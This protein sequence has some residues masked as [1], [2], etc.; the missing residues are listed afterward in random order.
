MLWID[1][2]PEVAKPPFFI[3]PLEP[4]HVRADFFCR[5]QSLTEYI[6]GPKAFN[7][8][9]NHSATVYV[10]IDEKRVVWGYFTLHSY[11]IA[12]H[13]LLSS[14]Y[15]PNWDNPTT[16]KEKRLRGGLHRSFAHPSINATLLGKIAIHQIKRGT[17]FGEMLMAKMLEKVWAGAQLVASRVL[18]LDAKND[19]LVGLYQQY[20][21]KLLSSE[22]R[23]MYMLMDTIKQFVE[24]K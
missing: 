10:C 17:D 11:S 9:S 3:E 6:T 7:D 5:E 22:D 20:D 14:L 23:R 19:T 18:I 12:R 15:G 8:T 24:A 13:D 1:P 2:H 16:P 21:F 4:T